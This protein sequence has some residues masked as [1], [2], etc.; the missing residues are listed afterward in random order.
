MY[1]TR[2]PVGRSPW[3]LATGCILFSLSP[4]LSVGP[5]GAVSSQSSGV[6]GAGDAA[7]SVPLPPL[8][9]APVSSWETWAAQQRSAMQQTNW[10]Q[11]LQSSDCTINSISI[12]PV[13]SSGAVAV[14]AG[15]VTDAV[16]LALSCTPQTSGGN[17]AQ[18]PA[19]IS[20]TSTSVSPASS[21]YCP[22]MLN[23][24]YG[25]IWGGVA[26][27]GPV[28]INGTTYMGAVYTYTASGSTYGH[29]ML[30][31]I[32]SGTCRPGGLVANSQP[33]T[34][35]TAGHVAMVIW[36]PKTVC[37]TWTSTWWQ[38]NGGG[39]YTD[40]GSVCGGY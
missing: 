28:A 10:A 4:L 39:N 22:Y 3:M 12:D 1:R 27:V 23:Y 15:I 8:P 20:G 36:G 13:V 14:P 11:V 37:T 34:T 9:G 29:T 38:D 32:S 16:S 33:E 21:T 25:G 31:A 26:C 40:F 19:A 7:S 17:S 5:A 18:V 35:L 30:G 24:T 6:S 2:S